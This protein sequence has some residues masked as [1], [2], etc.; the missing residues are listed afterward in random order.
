M[1]YACFGCAKLYLAA[2]EEGEIWFHWER[3]IRDADAP[4]VLPD[5]LPL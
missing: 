4:P 2:V 5:V 1:P 3:E